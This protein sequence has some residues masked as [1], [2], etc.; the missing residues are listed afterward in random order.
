VGTSFHSSLVDIYIYIYIQIT[1]NPLAPFE[2]NMHV[3]DR[4][5]MQY[6]SKN[7]YDDALVIH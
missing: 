3:H 1:N 6:Y 7:E 4:Q 5:C 2:H